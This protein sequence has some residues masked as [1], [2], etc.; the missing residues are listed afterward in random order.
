VAR[1]PT[2]RA[3]LADDAYQT[4]R[5]EILGLVIA[6]RTELDEAALVHRFA[7]SRT[8]VREATQAALEE[9]SARRDIAAAHLMADG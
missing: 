7:V 9:A 1:Q 6:P 5:Q 4:L 3:S 8:P 2:K